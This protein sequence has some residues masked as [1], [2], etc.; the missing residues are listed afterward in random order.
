M[1]Q[2]TCTVNIYSV[3]SNSRSLYHIAS[4]PFNVCLS[5]PFTTQPRPVRKSLDMESVAR[6]V[7]AVALTKLAKDASESVWVLDRLKIISWVAHRATTPQPPPTRIPTCYH[8]DYIEISF[9][10]IDD[11]LLTRTAS[12][13]IGVS[14]TL[15]NLTEER[16]A[17]DYVINTLQVRPSLEPK[18]H[19]T[20]S[21]QS[22]DPFLDFKQRAIDALENHRNNFSYAYINLTPTPVDIAALTKKSP[23]PDS[24]LSACAL[25]HAFRS[26][27][28]PPI[29][30]IISTTADTS[31]STSNSSF[32]SLD[33]IKDPKDML[34]LS[35]ASPLLQIVGLSVKWSPS[36][37]GELRKVIYNLAKEVHRDRCHSVIQCF[38][39][40]EVK[41][42]VHS[43]PDPNVV[44]NIK[45]L[46][47]HAITLNESFDD[48]HTDSEGLT[49]AKVFSENSCRWNWMSS[50]AMAEELTRR[51]T[52]AAAR[53]YIYL[54]GLTGEGKSTT[55]NR[56]LRLRPGERTSD[57]NVG[58]RVGSV[59]STTSKIQTGFLY[60]DDGD[61]S[62]TSTESYAIFRGRKADALWQ[63]IDTPGLSDDSGRDKVFIH[64]MMDFV[65][66]QATANLVLLIKQKAARIDEAEREAIGEYQK[67]FGKEFP[68]MLRIVCTNVQALQPTGEDT[69]CNQVSV[70]SVLQSA[71]ELFHELGVT[72]EVEKKVFFIGD[73]KELIIPNYGKYMPLREGAP[74]PRVEIERL[75]KDIRDSRPKLT[76]SAD[77]LR[78]LL[79][80]AKS[81][82]KNPRS[83]E[84]VTQ[85]SRSRMWLSE[86]V[87]SKD[88]QRSVSGQAVFTKNWTGV[89]GFLNRFM[90]TTMGS[91]NSAIMQLIFR[92]DTRLTKD[93]LHNAS[94]PLEVF[95]NTDRYLVA[96]VEESDVVDQRVRLIKRQFELIE[97]NQELSPQ[98]RRRVAASVL[99]AE[100][101][102]EEVRAGVSLCGADHKSHPKLWM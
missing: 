51:S 23:H 42:F 14:F 1:I 32:E 40:A 20:S 61:S 4:T 8:D 55:F 33:C 98:Q 37:D 81:F 28:L 86:Y 60:P 77:M 59:R 97:R 13:S 7:A 35:P 96:F 24:V 102:R 100:A 88:D 69:E 87:T 90:G 64:N 43:S 5:L 82:W 57:G 63:V 39:D 58:A 66:R 41:C 38:P 48:Q 45:Y 18:V 17:L 46:G 54:V 50:D 36:G 44:T 9:T 52:I 12:G 16:L 67:I 21:T 25:A 19:A 74:D 29:A 27:D 56:I 73:V 79:K 53:N 76:V 75:R 34:K 47:M 68:H 49:F 11:G 70:Q 22:K 62:D 30:D 71:R 3:Q 15:D 85:L 83:M 10:G 84:A 80:D 94:K 65:S 31:S 99:S 93:V 89:V 72:T 92:G 101:S 26:V 91:Y 78:E 2:C 6:Q 95:H